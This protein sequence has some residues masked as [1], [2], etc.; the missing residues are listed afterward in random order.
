MFAEHS[1]DISEYEVNSPKV[2]PQDNSCDCGFHV[3]LYI[4]GFE[5]I[6]INGITTVKIEP[7][8]FQFFFYSNSRTMTYVSKMQDMVYNFC[9]EI[10]RYLYYHESNQRNIV[11]E[12]AVDPNGEE[13]V[14]IIN[15]TANSAEGEIMG[16]DHTPADSENDTSSSEEDNLGVDNNDDPSLNSHT[17]EEQEGQRKD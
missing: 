10:S 15:P 13:A 4:K 8:A 6:D 11:N 7:C 1:F 2:L 5:L 12:V 16:R 17:T 9:K 3:L 14:E